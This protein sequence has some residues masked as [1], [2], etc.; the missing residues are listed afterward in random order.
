MGGV[1]ISPFVHRPDLLHPKTHMDPGD[2]GESDQ[3]PCEFY[4]E[5]NKGCGTSMFSTSRGS[6]LRRPFRRSAS[7][8]DPKQF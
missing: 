7:R 2:M 5:V 3:G 4:S 6:V 1:S 8:A